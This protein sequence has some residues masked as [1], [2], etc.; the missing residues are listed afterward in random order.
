MC[1]WDMSRNF[2]RKSFEWMELQCQSRLTV[3]RKIPSGLK[4]IELFK[5]IFNKE[6][7]SETL[8]NRPKLS[9]FSYK[10]RFKIFKNLQASLTLETS[11]FKIGIVLKTLLKSNEIGDVR[12]SFFNFH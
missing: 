6:N 8:R 3:K 9:D 2:S 4:Q 5:T 10:T 11:S 7:V 1:A 12:E